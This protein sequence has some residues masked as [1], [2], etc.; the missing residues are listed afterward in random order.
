[1]PISHHGLAAVEVGELAEDDGHRR[2][3]EQE[4]RRTPNCRRWRPPSC[5]TI[6][7]IAVED[8]RRLDGDHGHRGH[9]RRDDEWAGG[10]RVGGAW[11]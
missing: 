5:V 2:L 7:G 10:F 8:D 11:C 9:D 3:C 4:R 6:W 1:M